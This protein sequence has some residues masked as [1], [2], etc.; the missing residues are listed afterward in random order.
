[1]CQQIDVLNSYFSGDNYSS[2]REF[3]VLDTAKIQKY[4][5]TSPK[6]CL[7]NIKSLKNDDFFVN[8][9]QRIKKIIIF[10]TDYN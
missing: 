8:F 5:V 4:C 3:P 2:D 1:M 10:A 6:K 9:D 7:K